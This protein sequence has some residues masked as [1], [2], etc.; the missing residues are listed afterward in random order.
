LRAA[1]APAPD[2]AAPFAAESEPTTGSDERA[3]E[4]EATIDAAH[5]G[6]PAAGVSA[7]AS[8][9]TT[10]TT[11]PVAPRLPR[12]MAKP[13]PVPPATVATPEPVAPAPTQPKSGSPL[14]PVDAYDKH[15]KD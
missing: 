7:T 11:A 12:P 1:S 14:L 6:A 15:R 3:P 13:I 9:T 4:P 8:A 5:V 10:I 2:Q